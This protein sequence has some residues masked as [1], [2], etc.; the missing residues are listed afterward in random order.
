MYK[1]QD[2]FDENDN[3]IQKLLDDKYQ[4]HKAYQ[5][6]TSTQSKKDVYYAV[7]CKAWLHPRKL[8]DECFSQKADEIQSYADSHNWKLFYD[9]LKAVYGPQS[10]KSSPMLSTDGSTLLTDNDKIH[11]R[12]AEHFNNVLNFPSSISEEAI[13]GFPQVV[14]NPSLAESPT[15]EEVR[16]AFKA[17][18]T[19]K[20]PGSNAIP[21]KLYIVSR[22][23]L[24][25]KLTEL[26]KSALT[27]EAVPEE[28]KDATIF[29]LYKRKGN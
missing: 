26:F 15:V 16:R 13:A 3:E 6:D 24:I 29:H 18:S 27:S 17:C 19:G 9:A 7:H 10:S 4:A 22:M 23:N 21:G 8:W 14:I 25:S 12:W 28:F 20:A 1:H 2:W 11:G 5:N